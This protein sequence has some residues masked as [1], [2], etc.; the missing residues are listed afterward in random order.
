MSTVLILGASGMLGSAV[1]KEFSNFQGELVATTRVGASLVAGS[2]IRFLKFDAATDNLDSAFSMPIDYVINCIGII[3]PYIND[4]DTK[5][6]E[7][8]FEINGSFPNR[9]QAW[10]TKRGAK[11]IQIATDCVFSGSKGKYLETDEHDALDVYGKSKSL[12]EAKGASM[13]HLRVSIIG[14]EVDRSS[15]LLEWVRNQPKNAEISGYTDHFWN[16]ITSMHFA[17]IA[18]G[19]IENELFEPGVFNV[20]PKDSVT[21]SELVGLIAMYLGRSDIKVTP[22]ATGANINRTLDTSNPEKNNTLWLSA[23]YESPPS[24]ARMVSELITWGAKG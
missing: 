23:G 24:I 2:N 4:S 7:T 5:Q 13:M 3:K 10:A 9:L 19:V 6:T 15:S 16:G 11:V 1:L 12:G 21:K 20:L 18:R 17:K 22:T 8:A 14:P